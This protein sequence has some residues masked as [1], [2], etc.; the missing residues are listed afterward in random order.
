M[1]HLP[2][3]RILTVPLIETEECAA[4]FED[5]VEYIYTGNITLDMDTVD[6]IITLANKYQ[7]EDLESIA[8]QFQKKH[9]PGMFRKYHINIKDIFMEHLK[10]ILK[11][12]RQ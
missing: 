8:K 1:A 4:V 3:P 7:V 9:E 11:I 10:I 2:A 5:F 12:N 6:A